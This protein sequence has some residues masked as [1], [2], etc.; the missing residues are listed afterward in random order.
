MTG[1]IIK[2]CEKPRSSHPHLVTDE[3]GKI[4]RTERLCLENR[5]NCNNDIDKNTSISEEINCDKD[6]EILT[7]EG[8]LNIRGQTNYESSGSTETRQDDLS[9]NPTQNNDYNNRSSRIVKKT[10]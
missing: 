2:H 6:I 7:N 9:I 8:N 5:Y 10:Y 4:C 1:K 3:N